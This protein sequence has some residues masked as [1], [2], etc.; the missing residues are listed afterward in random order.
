MSSLWLYVLW[1]S[2]AKVV[3]GGKDGGRGVFKFRIVM[4]CLLLMC[5]SHLK[6]SFPAVRAWKYFKGFKS[7][8]NT[9]FSK[10]FFFLPLFLFF[11]VVIVVVVFYLIFWCGAA[12]AVFC[13][14]VAL[15]LAMGFKFQNI[16]PFISFN[17]APSVC[18]RMPVVDDNDIRLTV[19]GGMYMYICVLNSTYLGCY[20]WG[21]LFRFC[22]CFIFFVG[23]VVVAALK[24]SCV[25]YSLPR[26]YIEKKIQ[27]L[28]GFFL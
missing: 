13:P 26:W 22:F 16:F 7:V 9:Q 12:A 23:T 18:V 3:D 21:S 17:G 20:F 28:R 19:R 2:V 1:S 5:V 25:C 4:M 24:S 11:F 15:L 27:N 14:L 10:T 6:I 8:V